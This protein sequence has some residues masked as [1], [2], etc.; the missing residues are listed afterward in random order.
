ML[1][2]N[3]IRYSIRNGR[4]YP[5]FVKSDDPQLTPIA[6]ELIELFKASVGQ[7]RAALLEQS[8]LIVESDP[9]S[10]ITL[11]GLEKLLLDRTE[12]DAAPREEL[13]ASRAGIFAQTAELLTRQPFSDFREYEQALLKKLGKPRQE[14]AAELYQDLPQH[15]KVI[16]FRSLSAERLLHRYNAAQVQGLLMHCTQLQLTVSDANPAQFRQ[17]CKYLRFRQLLAEIRSTGPESFRIDIDGPLNLFFQVQKYGM[18][19]ALFFP[20][21]LHLPAWRLEADIRIKKRT[22]YQLILDHKS[23]L[24]PYSHHFLAYTPEE[25]SMFMV[26]FSNQVKEWEIDA[27]S[28]FLPLPGEAYCFPDFRLRHKNGAE[29]ALELFHPW[30]ARQLTQRLETLRDWPGKPP[31]IIGVSRELL[32]KDHPEEALAEHPY[33]SQY[34][35]LFRSTPTFRSVR[36]ILKKLEG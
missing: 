20:A 10:M 3:L 21:V 34:G 15:H 8:A 4:I 5:R 25:I 7:E 26:N 19:L 22:G 12:F 24:Q 13:I 14:L 6:A 28:D 32:K 17:L 9:A 35:F 27:G 23:K 29:I 36:A 31:L 11:R 33:F 2:K 18:N 16:R 1:T 30:H